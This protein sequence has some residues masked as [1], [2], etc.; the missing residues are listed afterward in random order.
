MATKTKKKAV[1]GFPIEKYI[2]CLATFDKRS[3]FLYIFSE[4]SVL[5]SV[6]KIESQDWMVMGLKG[7]QLVVGRPIVQALYPLEYVKVIK[8]R[9]K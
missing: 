2:G 3:G 5:S 4:S 6:N 1:S 9:K 7:D 8:I